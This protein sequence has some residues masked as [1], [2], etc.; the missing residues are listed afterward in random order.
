MISGFQD[1]G[2]EEQNRKPQN[3]FR[4]DSGFLCSMLTWWVQVI[5][6][7]YKV[8]GCA[9][10]SDAFVAS[11]KWQRCVNALSFR[12]CPTPVWILTVGEALPVSEQKAHGTPALFSGNLPCSFKNSVFLNRHYSQRY[13]SKKVTPWLMS[14]W[15]DAHNFMSQQEVQIQTTAEVPFHTSEMLLWKGDTEERGLKG[16]AGENKNSEPL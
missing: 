5:T 8:L 10:S 13:F 12:K 4:E 7:L 14:P 9:P 16:I 1:L 11:P 15:K 6:H 3:C 2:R